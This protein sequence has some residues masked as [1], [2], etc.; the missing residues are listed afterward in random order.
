[1]QEALSIL[2]QLA[3][4]TPE[5][6]ELNMGIA[7]LRLGDLYSIMQRFSDSEQAYQQALSILRQLVAKTPEVYEPYVARTLISLGDLYSTT[8]RLS[9]SESTCR[10]P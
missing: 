8:Q 5:V 10:K 9:D 6:Y 2:R 3:A 7:L 4:K 1:M